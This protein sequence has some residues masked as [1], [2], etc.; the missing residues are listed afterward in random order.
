MTP[1]QAAVPARWWEQPLD[2][3]LV[4]LGS[5]RSGLSQAAAA[6]RLA[7]EGPNAVG[8]RREWPLL[9]N[10]LA[11][12]AHPLIAVLI[13]ASLISA[14]LGDRASFAFVAVIVLLSVGLD[15]VQEHR[16]GNAVRAL[17][18]RV[19]LTAQVWR[20]G[21]VQA[22][23]VT[24]LVRGDVVE[25]AAGSLAPADGRL[26]AAR[27][28]FVK[29]AALT[30]E[31]FP[32]EK[33]ATETPPR[34]D[35]ALAAE[36][37]LL[38]GSSAVS[39]SGR[40]LVCAVGDATVLGGMAHALGDATPPTAFEIGTRAFSVLL[41]RM[42][43]G[44]VLFVLLTAG[45]QDR[46][47]LQSLLFAVALAVGLTPEL[48]PMIVSV[49]LARGAVRLAQQQVIVKRLAAIEDL[50]AMDV[51]ATDKTGTLTEASIR[52]DQH[53]DAQGRDSAAVFELAWLNSHFETGLKSGLDEAILAHALP[54]GF[55]GAGGWT[56]LDEVPFDFERRRVSVLVARGAEHR[57]VVKGAPEDLLAHCTRVQEGDAELALDDARRADIAA[58]IDALGEQGLRVL[59][60]AQR[61]VDA[62]VG[63]PPVSAADEQGLVFAGMLA[64]I[65][66]PKASAACA[67]R[68]LH[69][70]G[71]ACKIITGDS[72]AVTRHLAGALGLPVRGVLSGKQIA[73]LE[74]PALQAAAAKANL[75]C[76]IT[77]EQKN[78]IVL[79]LKARGHVVGFMG[80]GINDATALHSADVGI[81]V[82]DAVDVAKQAADLVLLQPDLAVLRQ[83]VVEGRRTFGN[84]MKYITMATS[85]NFGNMMSMAAASLVV[86]FLP[87][88]PVQILL[89]NFLYDLSEVA[90]PLDR[91]DAAALRRPQRW[92]VRYIRDFMLVFGALSSLFDLLTFALLLLV[93]KAGEAEFQSAWF[94]ESMATQ[95]LVVFVIRTRLA[96]WR[97]RPS[98]WLVAAALGV[99]AAA[100]VLPFTPLGDWFGFVPLPPWYL[101]AVAGLTVAYLAL[102]E[103]AK[104]LFH[105]LRPLNRAR[106]R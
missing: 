69:A 18:Q 8:R 24:A 75:F 101:V 27:D 20:D 39:G 28:L 50:G 23:P 33:H 51:L 85:S 13:A 57:L 36:G 52:L 41:T 80:D 44:L 55:D 34:C 102:V 17:Q 79:A 104:H 3:L 60:V 5:S 105:R 95:V 62:T 56:K 49:T 53:L 29:Q 106:P 84:V 76:R 88:L 45:V 89:N 92:N 63:A 58:R 54:A 1:I 61:S 78:R 65:D 66:P 103:V 32:V 22:L 26:L 42:T 7:A 99:T 74:A 38:M 97:S 35:S 43:V 91:V 46:P 21:A 93:L 2:S 87:M 48:L 37:T 9:L 59:A 70:L 31:P 81:S 67:L 40:M 11:R 83:G 71:V 72:E 90:L 19:A 4:E 6:Q 77:P 68:D 98:P 64:F 96:A 25:L 47:L 16:A 15:F 73:Q 30:G 100:A 86:P 12:L 10:F 82:D 94:V 14:L